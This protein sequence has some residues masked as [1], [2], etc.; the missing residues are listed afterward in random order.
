MGGGVPWAMISLPPPFCHPG[1]IPLCAHNTLGIVSVVHFIPHWGFDVWGEFMSP[2]I[3]VTVLPTHLAEISVAY[4][5]FDSVFS[6]VPN[7]LL[8][9]SI[10]FSATTILENL[11][12][13]F[14]MS[15]YLKESFTVCFLDSRQLWKLL[16]FLTFG[17]ATVFQYV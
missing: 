13:S 15:A 16:W 8:S 9:C 12:I 2:C 5:P 7:S 1:S 4:Y 6:H 17:L 14:A 10:Q 3:C 11:M